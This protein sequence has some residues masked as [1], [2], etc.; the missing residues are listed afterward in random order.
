MVKLLDLQAITLQ[1][2][3][4][5][6]AAINRV[7][8]SGWFLQGKENQQFEADYARYIGTEHC[9]AVAN[10]LDALKLI[11]RGY[12]E[13]GIMQD[14]DEIIV[15]ANTY[16][17]TIL[18][19]T[20]NNLVPILVEPTF[21]HLEIDI[22]QIEQHITPRTKG[23][24]TVHLYG[25][26]A[27]NDKLGEICQRHHL[28][29]MEDCAQ[30]HG[31]GFKFQD[32]SFKR[33]GALGDA[34]AHSFYP[35]KNLGALGDAGAV[36]T[37]DEELASVIRALANYGSQ[38]KYV[39]KYVGMN[40]RM[41]ET[42]AAVL[43][44]KLK[45][46]DEDNRK[47]QQLAAYYYANINNPLITLPKRIDDENNVYHQFPIFCERRDELQ[48]YLTD[49]GIQTLI[50]YPIPPHKQECYKEWNHRSYPITEKI[51]AQELSIP[52]NQVITHQEAVEVVR[53]LN[54]F[55]NKRI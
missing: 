44:I 36:T 52:M 35:G 45:Y 3:D 53:I 37:D 27:Y 5:Y 17:A 25:R 2:I 30:S 16:I 34:A 22:D 15:P 29:L 51:H 38:K 8:E 32:S 9:I 19:I 24:M 7:V 47:R 6:E 26:I 20:E 49:N 42:D 18:A 43:D 39:F 33:T 23:V 40:S 46:L 13:M 12:K 50:H 10:G 21:E 11:L 54:L 4:E 14:G 48:Q 28:K 31:C 1:H 41:A 55:R